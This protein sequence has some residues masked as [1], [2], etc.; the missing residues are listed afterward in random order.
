MAEECEA[1]ALERVAR[2]WP[3]LRREPATAYAVGRR[4]ALDELRRLTGWRRRHRA[5]VV[6]MPAHDLE[7]PAIEAGYDH[8][9]AHDELTRKVARLRPRDQVIT[10]RLA[11]G[12][13]GREVAGSLGV[14]PSI[15]SVA[16]RRISDSF[17]R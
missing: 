16:L 13:N 1:A 10:L 2:H 15:V 4:A 11:A 5:A 17:G 14:S 9:D 8:V 6:P 3:R 7:R 12:F